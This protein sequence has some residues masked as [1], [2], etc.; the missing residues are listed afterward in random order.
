MHLSDSSPGE[1]T[2]G[3]RNVLVSEADHP[4][5]EWWWPHGHTIGWEHS[6]VHE[7][8]HLLTAIRDD[9][10]IAPARRDLRGRLPLRRGVRRHR[11]LGGEW[12]PGGGQLPRSD[13]LPRLTPPAPALMSGRPRWG[14]A[15]RSE[16]DQ[17]GAQAWT[18]AMS[19]AAAFARAP[20]LRG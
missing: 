3:F 10:D 5:W 1:Q 18:L 20:P 12:A 6:F 13:D 8:H 16:L 11:A 17:P 4:F 14:L 7:L 2:Q 9:S 19:G 15:A